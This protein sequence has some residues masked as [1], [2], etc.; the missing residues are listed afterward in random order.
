MARAVKFNKEVSGSKLLQE[1]GCESDLGK[2]RYVEGSTKEYCED[3]KQITPL[4]EDMEED[5]ENEQQ[6]DSDS[7][8]D[9]NVQNRNYVR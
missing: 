9:D 2:T 4:I 5:V 8:C 3:E 1:S 7:L 6:E